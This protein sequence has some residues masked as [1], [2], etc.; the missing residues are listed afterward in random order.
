MAQHVASGNDNVTQCNHPALGRACACSRA[1]SLRRK[2]ASLAPV[3]AAAPPSKG[4]S[5]WQKR[6][7]KRE[8]SV[9]RSVSRERTCR[10][11]ERGYDGAV[12]AGGAGVAL[13]V[14]LWPE[15]PRCAMSPRESSGRLKKI[16][17][18]H[19]R[20]VGLL[21]KIN[22]RLYNCADAG[23]HPRFRVSRIEKTATRAHHTATA[24][25]HA[26][27]STRTSA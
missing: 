21:T 23:G 7:R 24:H 2:P 12:R 17:R 13:E 14:H 6:R 20:T 9:S 15:T 18:T 16:R 4:I 8:E 25:A 3:S 22:V 27:T 1:A 10:A 11:V 26:R 19:S 5:L